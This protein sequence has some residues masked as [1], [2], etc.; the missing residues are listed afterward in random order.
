VRLTAT[1]AG[2]TGVHFERERYAPPLDPAWIRTP[3]FAPLRQASMQLAE[4]FAGR[5]RAFDVPLSPEGTPFQR[6]VWDAIATVPPGETISY[7]E[8]ARRAGRPRSV[9]AAGGASGAQPACH[10]HPA[11]GSSGPTAHDRIRRRTRAQ[12]R[13]AR[14]RARRGKRTPGA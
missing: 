12:A 6:A 8:L 7:A 5:R 3:G 2:L 4:Y 9:L 10:R 14:P 13:A 1:S 11:T